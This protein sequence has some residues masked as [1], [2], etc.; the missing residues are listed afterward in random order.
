MEWILLHKSVMWIDDDDAKMGG[1]IA[2]FREMEVEA[3]ICSQVCHYG[4]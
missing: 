1:K 2:T 3:D 4:L